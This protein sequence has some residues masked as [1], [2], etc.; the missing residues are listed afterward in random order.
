MVYIKG[1]TLI[2]LLI[3]L[4]ISAIIFGVGIPSFDNLIQ[5]NQTSSTINQL[6]RTLNYARTLSV[7]SSKVVTICP[8][9]E[10]SCGKDWSAGVLIFIDENNNGKLDASEQ[11]DR[12]AL[13]NL[14]GKL[15]WAAFGSQ[16]YLKY[17]PSGSTFQ[18]NGSFTYC[19]K[20]NDPRYA[21]QIIINTA[22]RIRFAQDS[23]GNGIRENTKGH[24]LNCNF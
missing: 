23:D 19:H 8:Q 15:K 14:N 11:I 3:T 16:H 17:R 13:L 18:Q 1:F 12:Q 21:H 10:G 6:A 22:G 2:D 9:L 24:D 7:T 5:K 20:N 4:S